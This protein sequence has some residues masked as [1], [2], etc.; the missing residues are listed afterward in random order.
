ML[1]KIALVGLVML[2]GRGSTAQLVCALLLSFVFFSLQM[3]V[4]PYK[5]DQDNVRSL[6]I[7]ASVLCLFITLKILLTADL[8]SC[9]GVSRLHCDRL[10]NDPRKDRPHARDP[11]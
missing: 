11:D 3:K 9:H 10:C 2:V 6:H 7:T 1:R 5:I 8:P 4:C